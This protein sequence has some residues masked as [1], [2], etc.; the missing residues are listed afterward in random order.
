VS[1]E[2]QR[3]IVEDLRTRA[4]RAGW[5]PWQLARSI[6]QAVR[7]PT[8]LMAWRLAAGLTQAQLADAVRRLA[9]DTGTPCSPTTP[10][11]QQV[12]RW[13][14]GHDRP[15]GFYQGLLAAWY[16]TDP[17][18]LGL[19]GDVPL[20]EPDQR[21]LDESEVEDHVN[22]R[23]FLAVAAVPALAQLDQIRRR[24]DADLRHSLP[25]AETDHWAAIAD[26]HVAAYGTDS[27]PAVLLERLAPDLS[28]LA[29]LVSQYPQQRNLT[30]LAA[31]LCGLTGALHTDL[32]DDRAARDWLHTAARYAAM[33]GDPAI[34]YWVAMA[35]AML[36][37]Y[38]PDPGRVLTIAARAATEF[39][40]HPGAA[41]AQLTG[42]TARAHAALGDVASARAQLGRAEQI[43]DR[44]TPAQAGAAF[45]GFPRRELLMYQ[46]QVLTVV[47]DN[48]AW[49][50]QADALA[51]YPADDRMDRPLLLLHRAQYLAARGQADHA[52]QIAVG[53]IADLAPPWRV[54]LLTRQAQVLG[55][56]ITAVS[57]QVGRQYAATL[58]ATL[59]A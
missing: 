46:A 25:A 54:P 52:A 32:G 9:A 49:T 3:R 53:A 5:T 57:P 23:S 59:A 27:P 2:I 35:Q 45:F 8:L 21:H 40:P 20:T 1:D 38:R 58:R 51:Q 43:A 30:E 39:G 10:S 28:D 37:T 42:L 36:A 16:R 34:R 33:S 48:A 17:A 50:A 13:E 29:D 11:C 31:R 22:R 6:H 18:R 4:M 7:T 26:Q 14:N 24:M 47:G 12:S 44:L 15:G 55:R 41:A 56:D 19:I